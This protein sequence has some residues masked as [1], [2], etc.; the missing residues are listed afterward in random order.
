MAE[1]ANVLIVGNGFAGFGCAQKLVPRLTKAGE[2]AQVSLV[3]PTNYHLYTPLLADVAGGVINPRRVAVPLAQGLPGVR[4][5]PGNVESIDLQARTVVVVREGEEQPPLSWDRLVLTPGSVTRLFD[6]PGLE[7]HARGLKTVAEAMYLHDH[8]IRQI[9]LSMFDEDDKSRKGRRTVVIVG[10]SY[11]GTEL[12][13]Q[14]RALADEA[15]RRH[16]L[17]SDD[18]D[19]LLLDKADTVMPEVGTNLGERALKVLKQRGID[20]RLGMSLSSVADD[21]VVLEDGARVE[22]RTVAWVAG[23][24]PSPLVAT[25][26]LP[27]E[28]GRLV[29]GP[30]LSVP[31]HPH[32]FAAGD[33]AAVP[34]LTKPGKITP[35]TAQHAL[36]QG[37]ALAR[38][39]AASLGVGTPKDYKHHDLG[40]VVD[41]GPGYAVADPVGLHLS[42]LPAKVV[43]RGYHLAALPLGRNRLGV[44]FD[45]FTDLVS[46]RPVLQLGMVDAQ[47]SS[48]DVSEHRGDAFTA[49]KG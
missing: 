26:G 46:P 20:V 3:S 42:G 44:A 31:D 7:E 21:H 13:A 4:L 17:S 39:V 15:S 38:N 49:P 29:V 27:T 40:L 19:F 34:D 18:I 30:D 33:A 23:V 10:A 41:L 47:E 48:F 14:L 32:V 24:E 12:V 36:R 11:A 45:W 28:K 2:P 43:T 22:T 37:H 5:V 25:L 35:P 6:I 1:R 8:L 9:E 16:G